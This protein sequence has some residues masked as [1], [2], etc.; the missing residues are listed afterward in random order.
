MNRVLQEKVLILDRDGTLIIEKN[1]LSNPDD[2]EL[3][4]G[5]AEA[6][7]R[8]QVQ[9]WKFVVLT[10][11]SGVGRGMFTL[12]DVHKVHE[13][14]DA[15]L[16]DHNVTISAYFVSPEHPD[17][18]SQTRKPN[19][20]MLIQ[21]AEAFHFDPSSVIIVGDKPA[22]IDLGRNVNA[23]TVL[24]RTGYGA[25]TEAISSSKADY[26]IDDLSHIESVINEL[27]A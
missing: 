1:Y 2:V 7:A 27:R 8:L 9:G 21:A 16:Q 10:N 22:D 20:G 12:E 18:P 26:T 19:P 4:P 5:A 14:I 13:R 25:D 23:I 17:T 6:L 3:I 24:V 11:Q 15:L